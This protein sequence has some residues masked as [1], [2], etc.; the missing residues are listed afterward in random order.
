MIR[1]YSKSGLKN[2]RAWKIAAGGLL[3]ALTA[4][5][6]SVTPRS[7]SWPKGVVNALLMSALLSAQTPGS[8][9][10]SG[11]GMMEPQIVK[12]ADDYRNAVLSGDARAV[13]AMYRE[14]GIELPNCA[15]A[16]RGRA[17]IEQRYREFFAGPVKVTA[18]TFTHIE[19]T[20]SGELAYDVGTYEQTLS[21]PGGQTTTDKGKYVAVVKR[22]Q[23]QW[24]LA[25]LIYNTDTD[26][27]KPR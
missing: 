18:F 12:A 2:G 15:P 6:V 24:K 14:D 10:R 11:S 23:G 25:Y 16:T 22:A 13:A 5:A 26:P 1:N 21:L 19:A 4:I 20:T 3:V 7:A 8:A 9:V 27:A 17:A